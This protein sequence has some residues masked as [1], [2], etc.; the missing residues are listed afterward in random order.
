MIECKTRRQSTPTPAARAHRHYG[1]A[2]G[3]AARVRHVHRVRRRR[4]RSLRDDGTTSLFA[5]FSRCA[6][7][8]PLPARHR[9]TPDRR[10]CALSVLTRRG[11]HGCSEN[12]PPCMV[13]E[14]TQGTGAARALLP[15]RW[16]DTGWHPVL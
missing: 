5:M 1:H 11:D 6:R 9:H 2:R 14:P 15:G 4:T 16:L 7:R 13:P 8:R 10:R 3:R 12:S